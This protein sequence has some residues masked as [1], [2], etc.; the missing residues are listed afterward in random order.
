PPSGDAS[1]PSHGTINQSPSGPD[2]LIDRSVNAARP[3][4]LPLSRVRSALGAP[5]PQSGRCPSVVH[6]GEPYGGFGG[7]SPAG[8][9][10]IERFA[11]TGT[12]PIQP[13]G[14]AERFPGR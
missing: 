7:W 10:R 11:R 2:R 14:R 4:L 3:R 12:A 8:A 13:R 5:R 6:W 9:T 1:R